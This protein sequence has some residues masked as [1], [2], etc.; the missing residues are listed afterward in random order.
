MLL[1]RRPDWSQQL[2][3]TITIPEVM[4]LRT[5]AD[6][7]ELLGH[8]PER[9]R[10]KATWEYVADRLTEAASNGDT[11]SVAVPLQMVL[12]LEGVEYR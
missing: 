3:R 9:C 5:L 2:P 1:R 4:T 10:Y 11:Q 6:V 7:R 12:R 8:L